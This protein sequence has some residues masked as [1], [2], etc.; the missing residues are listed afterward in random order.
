MYT[1]LNH[2]RNNSYNRLFEKLVYI[3]LFLRDSQ[4]KYKQR[5]CMIKDE[6][7]EFENIPSK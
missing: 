3:I 7:L 2:I 6:L 5:E 4:F 1:K